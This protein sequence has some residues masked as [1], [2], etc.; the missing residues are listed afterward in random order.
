VCQPQRDVIARA[1]EFQQGDSIPDAINRLIGLKLVA[2]QMYCLNMKTTPKPRQRPKRDLL[3]GTWL[4]T[5]EISSEVEYII[6]R[7]SEA[8]N[9]QVRDGYDGEMADI[10]EIA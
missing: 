4:D 3:A 1:E 7:S 6:T 2:A 5:S 10:F 9:V 8:Y